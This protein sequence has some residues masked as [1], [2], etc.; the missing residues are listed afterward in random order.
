MVNGAILE[1][2]NRR[3]TR[4]LE[5]EAAQPPRQ[6]GRGKKEGKVRGPS[7][8][9]SGLYRCSRCGEAAGDSGQSSR[10][11]ILSQ[12]QQMLYHKWQGLWQAVAGGRQ[13]VQ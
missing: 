4:H 5:K 8:E 2:D 3:V 6:N 12:K 1:K 11:A 7:R 10:R 9:R 13:T